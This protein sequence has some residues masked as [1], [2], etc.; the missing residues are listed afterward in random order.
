LN[1]NQMTIVELDKVQQ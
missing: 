1:L